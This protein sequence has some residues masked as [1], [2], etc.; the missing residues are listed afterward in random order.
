LCIVSLISHDD[1]FL[2]TLDWD[3]PFRGSY[4]ALAAQ[5]SLH[6]DP[7]THKTEWFHPFTLDAKASNDG[8][9]TLSH[10]R[11]LPHRELDLWYDSMDL[12]LME[13]LFGRFFVLR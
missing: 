2:H 3:G 13:E 8:T 9:P 5:N 1:I 7:L 4:T 6:I 12:E 11:S 10:I